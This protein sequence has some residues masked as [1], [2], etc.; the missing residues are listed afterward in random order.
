MPTFTQ[1]PHGSPPTRHSGLVYDTIHAGQTFLSATSGGIAVGWLTVLALISLLLHLFAAP[2]YGYFRDELYYLACADHLEVGYVDH[3]PLSIFLLS[4]WRSVFGDSLFALRSLPALAGAGLVFLVGR[5]T[6]DLGGGRFAQLLAAA[7]VVASPVFL[8]LTRFYS[9]NAFELVLWTVC[10]I[11][12]L[13]AIDRRDLNSWLVLGLVF[14]ATLLNKLSGAWVIGGIFVGLALTDSRRWLRRPE[15]W[16]ALV[17]GLLIFLPHL[18]WQI[19]HEWPTIEFIRNA[20]QQ[21]MLAG[22]PARF[23]L[24]QILGM[25]P[26][27][28]PLW[29]GALVFAFT[30]PWGRRGRIFAWLYLSVAALLVL[31]ASSRSYYLA[32][33]YP[34]LLALGGVAWERWS[35]R[36]RWIRPLLV[37]P[38][39]FVGVILVPL[40]LPLLPVD[41]FVRYQTAL[42]LTPRTEERQEIGPL[43]QDYADMFGW[44]ELTALVARAY[45]TIPPEEQ[46]GCR[47]FAQNYGQAA[48]IDH[49]GPRLG[50]PRALCGHNSYALWGAADDDWE[51]LIL[52]GGSREDHLKIFES[53]TVIGT[54]EAKYA[55]PA[56][57]GLE[58]SVARGLKI[59]K[60]AALRLARHLI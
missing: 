2:H 24:D 46:A 53:V 59:P 20:T 48:A 60:E 15:P 11:A 26:A 55:L 47:V 5:L 57:Q 18:F 6:R 50:L 37:G 4:V 8:A 33:A 9:M 40:A 16:I 12:A 38:L 25:N 21:K 43:P 7:A 49:F 52:I 3:P 32:A 41:T 17:T 42:G 19:A 36:R 1:S 28:L 54:T 39:V 30:S 51:T 14:G 13:R 35:D 56:E 44:E 31:S 58:V 23:L 29:L 45:A 27:S 34:P 10:A 22:S